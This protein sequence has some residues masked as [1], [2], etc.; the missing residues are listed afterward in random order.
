MTNIKSFAFLDLETTGLPKY[1]FSRTKITELSV[2]ACS[3]EHLLQS[4]TELPRVVHKLSLC[5]NPFR[6]ISHQ[7]SQSTGLY[8]D[9]LQHEGTFDENAG[10]LFKLFLFRLQKPVC[11]VAHN[12]YR[13]DFVLLKKQLTSIGIS[14]EAGSVVC[15]DTIPAFR[16]IEADIERSTLENCHGMDDAVAELEY[17]TVRMLD[18]LQQSGS[19]KT[20]ELPQSLTPPN[21]EIERKHKQAVQAYLVVAP[22]EC[23]KNG[24]SETTTD[25]N[26]SQQSTMGVLECLE[27]ASNFMEDQR[28]R[29]EKTPQTARIGHKHVNAEQEDDFFE[30][31]QKQPPAPRPS[32]SSTARKR[33]FPADSSTEGTQSTPRKRYNLTELYKRT[34]G[35]DIQKAHRAEHDTMALLECVAMHAARFIVYAEDHCVP[36][37]SIKGSF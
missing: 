7:S 33:L 8:N 6:M 27:V 2:V 29:N 24:T 3:R 19:T 26:V 20:E 17:H 5:F 28:K 1:E 36:F 21:E 31:T 23:T 12:G 10:E 15:I 13:F 35:R 11:L 34:V 14:L 32:T 18:N 4:T 25:D 37:E 30:Q 22:D 16:S 9:L